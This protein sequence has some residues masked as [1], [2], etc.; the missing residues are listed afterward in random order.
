MWPNY[1]C[2]NLVASGRLMRDPPV[3]VGQIVNIYLPAY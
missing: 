1:A 2:C 3:L